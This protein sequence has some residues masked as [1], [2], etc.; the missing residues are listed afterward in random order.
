MPF[1]RLDAQSLSGDDAV[2]VASLR[3]KAAYLEYHDAVDKNAELSLD[4]VKP[5]EESLLH[6][7]QAYEKLDSARQALFDAAALAH[8]TL[9]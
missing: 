8:P 9:H 2:E 5:S 1:G 7:E 6:E 3:Y 4:G